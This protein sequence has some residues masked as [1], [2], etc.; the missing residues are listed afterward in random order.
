MLSSV[1]I[2]GSG[3][4]APAVCRHVPDEAGRSLKNRCNSTGCRRREAGSSL[5][6]IRR[7][8]G[9]ESGLT[10]LRS[11]VTAIARKTARRKPPLRHPRNGASHC[12]STPF[13]F[14]TL[15]PTPDRRRPRPTGRYQTG[16]A[17]DCGAPETRTP[18]T[19]IRARRCHR[20]RSRVP[21]PAAGVRRRT[22]EPGP[23]RTAAGVACRLP[24]AWVWCAHLPM[25]PC[26]CRGASA[27]YA[28]QESG[29]NAAARGQ[30]DFAMAAIGN[31]YLASQA[32]TGLPAPPDRVLPSPFL[33]V[34]EPGPVWIMPIAALFMRSR[35]AMR[36]EC[37][38][39]PRI[40]RPQPGG[41]AGRIRA[42][43]R[44]M[45]AKAG[46]FGIERRRDR[47]GH[48]QRRVVEMDVAVGSERG[49]DHRWCAFTALDG[50]RAQ[51]REELA[52]CRETVRASSPDR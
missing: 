3:G 1:K 46:A 28:L 30:L 43:F 21:E 24:A 50:P 18:R 4:P 25:V 14:R 35:H 52:G 17:G 40:A 12:L 13:R 5:S 31:L 23:S 27:G 51:H 10:T 32:A 2:G 39:P 19:A 6:R 44:R 16:N 7:A 33:L 29:G 34:S 20:G 48:A 9:Y 41:E 11:I 42:A 26:P 45:A 49:H 8:A 36:P 15:A 47:T 37:M 22:A 38:A